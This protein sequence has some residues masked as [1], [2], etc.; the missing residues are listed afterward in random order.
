MKKTPGYRLLVEPECTN[1]CFWYIPPS[2]RGQDET[3]EWWEKLGK[4]GCTCALFVN[5]WMDFDQTHTDTYSVVEWKDLI[6]MT[7]T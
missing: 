4:V 5:P 1:V 2:L 3:K 6:F 7:L